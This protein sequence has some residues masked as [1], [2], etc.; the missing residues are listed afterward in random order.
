[1][2]D[3]G[4]VN[5]QS[6]HR[7][8]AGLLIRDQVIDIAQA[9][10]SDEFGQIGNILDRWDEALSV[11]DALATDAAASRIPLA[12]VQLL[13]PVPPP[14]AVYG[15]GANYQK[16][17][18]NMMRATNSPAQP[19]AR[20]AG[21]PPYFFLKSG[22]CVV[23]T[24]TE[25]RMSGAKMDWEAELAV[26]IGRKAFDLSPAQAM[27][28][29]AGYTVANDLS[30]RDRA[31]RKNGLPTSPFFF[32]FVAQK[33]FDGSCPLGP[34][35]I[36]AHCLGD[37]QAL[38]MKLWVNDRLRIDASTAEMIYPI[39]EQIAFLS[40]FATLYPGDIVLTGTP[41]G[42]GAET[43]EFLQRGDR[44]RVTIEGIGTI[45]NTIV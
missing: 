36:P 14:L 34:A 1:M 26:V 22:H 45:E 4:V 23:P 12:S 30:A 39:A 11:L 25:V 42:V 5:Y 28:C 21:M 29:I 33:S 17:L 15:I 3:Y 24:G 9:T 16:H 27:Q 20:D 38:A 8:R 19:N 35:L 7:S 18:D 44:V 37:P 43:G 41:A 10:G 2:L 40:S 6:Q 32:D 31:V 13:A